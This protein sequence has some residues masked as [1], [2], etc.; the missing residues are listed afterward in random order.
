MSTPKLVESFYARIWNAGDLTAVPDLLH[1]DFHFR[2][3]LGA[4][5]HG[6]EAFKDYVRAVRHALADYRCEILACVA[7]GNTA[8][9]KMKFSG[10]HVASFRGFPATGKPVH[11]LASAWFRFDGE[12]IADLW[13]VS[14]IAVLDALLTANQSGSS[15]DFSASQ[16]RTWPDLHSSGLSYCAS[17][18]V[19]SYH[20][21]PS[22]RH[23]RTRALD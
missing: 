12:A 11:W 13:V 9:A 5:L 22:A 10:R 16:E 20:A 6:H 1:P 18:P 14:D 23:G 21:C 8:S 3:S 2:G 4:E 17:S 7:E 19:K 15:T